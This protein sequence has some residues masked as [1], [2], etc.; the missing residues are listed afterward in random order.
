MSE[1]TDAIERAVKAACDDPTE[2]GWVDRA[3]DGRNAAIALAEE[4]EA[5]NAELEA[6]VVWADGY[7][8]DAVRQAAADLREPRFTAAEACK[9][10]ALILATAEPGIRMTD[11]ERGALV[12]LLRTGLDRALSPKEAPHG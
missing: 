3:R 1:L 2:D 6:A 12:A 4:L 5:R 10:F 8:R 9:A 11:F 7:L